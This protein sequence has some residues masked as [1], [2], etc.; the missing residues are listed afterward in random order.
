MGNSIDEMNQ[1]LDKEPKNTH[2]LAFALGAL[3]AFVGILGFPF[4]LLYG[5]RLIG[6]PV[7]ISGNSYI[8]AILVFAFIT[9]TT[10]IASIN[11]NKKNKV[12]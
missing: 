4:T 6:F 3:I 7:V 2:K 8:G 10:K 12:Q 11:G 9:V 5:L 1:S